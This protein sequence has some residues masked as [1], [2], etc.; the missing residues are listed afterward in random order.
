MVS[1]IVDRNGG[2]S[3][4]SPVSDRNTGLA[5]SAATKAPCRVASVSNITLSGLQ[6]IDGVTVAALDRV[7][8][9]GQTDTTLNGIYIVSSG[10]WKRSPDFSRND[11]VVKGCSVRVTSGTTY[12]GLWVL[13]S[14]DPITMGTSAITLVRDTSLIPA[15]ALLAANNFSDL[16]SAIAGWDALARYD[17]AQV[18]APAAT[19]L[20]LS[21][22]TSPIIDVSTGAVSSVTLANH[23]V[24]LARLTGTVTITASATLTVDGNTSGTFIFKTPSVLLFEGFSTGVRVITLSEA[25]QKGADVA[26]ATT[27]T[28]GRDRLYHITGTTTITDID[29][30]DALDGNW[31]WLIFDGILTLTYNSTTLKMPGNASITTAAGDRA[32]VVQDSG[33]NAIVV[34]YIKADGTAVVSSAV[35]VHGQTLATFFPF[36]NEPPSSNYATLSTR[37]GHPILV[38][39]DAVVD[40]AIFTG[41]LPASYGGNGL[42]IDLLWMNSTTSTNKVC[43]SATIEY[44]DSGTT[45]FDADSFGTQVVDGTGVAANATSGIASTTT[46]ALTSGAQMDSL[47]AGKSYRLKI[48]R[49]TGQGNDTQAGDAQLLSVHVKE[50]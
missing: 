41:V 14:A 44:M 10:V 11:D 39:P 38:F 4:S 6:T 46:L 40:V 34:N 9:T 1:T 48:T 17:S 18:A 25:R 12:S 32:L 5:T 23:K 43:W 16:A 26:S 50:T 27:I 45:D 7:L 2:T 37:N 30:S 20:D 47:V 33:D 19:V 35:S 24:R 31:A 49:E 13:T 28:L 42:T 21:T 8:V 3:S 22:T 29:W 36:D 15:G